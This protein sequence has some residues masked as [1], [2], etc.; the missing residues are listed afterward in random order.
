MQRV[1]SLAVL[2]TRIPKH[3]DAAYRCECNEHTDLQYT[4]GETCS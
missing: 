4:L 2:D 1:S 3:V